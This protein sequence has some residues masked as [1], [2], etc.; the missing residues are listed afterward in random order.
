MN[1]IIL[2]PLDESTFFDSV[3]PK[4]AKLINT[5]PPKIKLD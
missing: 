1:K 5:K 3:K 4:M 2:N